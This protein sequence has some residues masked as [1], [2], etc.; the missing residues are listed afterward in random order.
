M[1]Q[2][3]RASGPICTPLSLSLPL[4]VQLSLPRPVTSSV[5]EYL[6]QQQQQHCHFHHTGGEMYWHHGPDR[7]RI[8]TISITSITVSPCLFSGLFSWAQTAF[9]SQHRSQFVCG[10]LFPLIDGK[11]GFVKCKAVCGL[12]SLR[13]D[14]FWFVLRGTC[15]HKPAG[16]GRDA[17]RKKET[18]NKTQMRCEQNTQFS[19]SAD[20]GQFSAWHG[21]SRWVK[22]PPP[23]HYCSPPTPPAVGLN[24]R[25]ADFLQF[26]DVWITFRSSSFFSL[27]LYWPW[28]VIGYISFAEYFNVFSY[29][30]CSS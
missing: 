29:Y 10:L 26:M 18:K 16:A 12:D 24:G 1:C 11:V 27:S 7:E 25:V 4:S 30:F 14:D 5:G 6:Q 13:G 19:H 22:H 9:E 17:E 8:T 15:S 2:S 3:A 23:P 21:F 20:L 28:S